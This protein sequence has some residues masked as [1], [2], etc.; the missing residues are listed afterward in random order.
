MFFGPW[1]VEEYPVFGTAS[2]TLYFTAD[3]QPMDWLIPEGKDEGDIF[4]ERDPD[5]DGEPLDQAVEISVLAV[6]SKVLTFWIDAAPW[7]GDGIRP[8]ACDF[9]PLPP[10][11]RKTKKITGPAG[12]L[13]IA[14]SRDAE[15][16]DREYRKVVSVGTSPRSDIQKY[17]YLE[18]VIVR[19]Q[20]PAILPELGEPLD[21]EGLLPVSEWSIRD[22]VMNDIEELQENGIDAD[23]RL[24][25]GIPADTLLDSVLVENLPLGIRFTPAS[26]RWSALIILP[27]QQRSAVAWE[28]AS[29]VR[30]GTASY[31]LRIVATANITIDHQTFYKRLGPSGTHVVD[32]M[33][34][35][36]RRVAADDLGA[37]PAQ[38]TPLHEQ[39][40]SPR[41]PREHYEDPYDQFKYQ[42]DIAMTHLLLESPGVLLLPLFFIN[43]TVGL[44]AAALSLPLALAG[45]YYTLNERQF[46][47]KYG[48]DSFGRPV[49]R[50][51]VEQAL[52]FSIFGLVTDALGA[53]GA[54]VKV[55]RGAMALAK[56][57]NPTVVRGMIE[58][59]PAPLRMALRRIRPI[60][61]SRLINSADLAKPAEFL[62]A[63][64]KVARKERI[65]IPPTMLDLELQKV[66]TS[67][68]KGFRNPE[69]QRSYMSY[70]S[71]KEKKIQKKLSVSPLAGEQMI[72]LKMILEPIDWI[73]IGSRRARQVAGKMLGPEWADKI[74]AFRPHVPIDATEQAKLISM[75][76]GIPY[77][78][79]RDFR[80]WI[81]AGK[82]L[83]DLFQSVQ[84][85]IQRELAKGFQKARKA[86]RLFEA[87]HP[88]E[89]RFVKE[90]AD[91][92]F[93]LPHEVESYQEALTLLVPKN[94]RVARRLNG[95]KGYV[96]STKTRRMEVL[97]AFGRE[98]EYTLQETRDAHAFT[99][100]SLAGP[101]SPA[102]AMIDELVLKIAAKTG[103]V[104]KVGDLPD[105]AQFAVG[106][107]KYFT[108]SKSYGMRAKE[109]YANKE[110]LADD[111][112]G[113]ARPAEASW[114]R[115]ELE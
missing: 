38:G 54:A 97:I 111:L 102:I 99:I 67:D 61:L 84:H 87:D 74:R 12:T 46:I 68:Y 77:E 8:F 26:R 21:S 15:L 40:L 23:E 4:E 92:A 44:I 65:H 72:R 19:V 75:Q 105:P 82:S 35:Q 93:M 55:T 31:E 81:R 95:Y 57:L 43:P 86:E 32:P 62:E 70:V 104:V 22:A 51:E 64:A 49:S 60:L 39:K 41:P 10:E 115:V 48:V 100:L 101:E 20:D 71:K 33:L 94:Q 11:L 63:F 58:A 69:L 114:P 45:L 47:L 7:N 83:S 56:N 106:K 53:A 98:S 18:L 30:T 6:F 103:D 24:L 16:D 113:S 107:W 14:L 66:F 3:G 78:V 36:I 1:H 91:R 76:E 85:P 34:V 27:A 88:F 50:D 112:R 17:P 96:H 37:V 59:A 89:N 79:S 2:L 29:P 110:L 13:V 9:Y 25:R 28:L 80:E 108:P 109:Y 5:Y 90:F 52:A 42:T 73:T